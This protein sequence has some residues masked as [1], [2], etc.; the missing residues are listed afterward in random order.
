M[1]KPR[2]AKHQGNSQQGAAAMTEIEALDIA[3]HRSDWLLR[4]HKRRG[5]TGSDH[6]EQ[7]EHEIEVLLGLQSARDLIAGLNKK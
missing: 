5:R 2:H 6:S 1:T 4:Q 7:I 3:I